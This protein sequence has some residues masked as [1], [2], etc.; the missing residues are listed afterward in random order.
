[1]DDLDASI[2]VCGRLLDAMK[3]GASSFLSSP[4]TQIGK[5]VL[6][7]GLSV[8][9]F[10]QPALECCHKIMVMVKTARDVDKDVKALAG[11]MP[12]VVEYFVR[13]RTR[14]SFTLEKIS[15][16]ALLMRQFNDLLGC[17]QEKIEKWI[18]PKEHS[19]NFLLRKVRSN[20]E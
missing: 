7:A 13:V 19:K 8:F 15:S 11:L 16:L 20:P 17:V 9:P 4:A 2:D 3:D 5:E 18:L 6:G 14:T 1:M 10:V 12:Q